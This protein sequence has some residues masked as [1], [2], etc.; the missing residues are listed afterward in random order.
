MKKYILLF[1]SAACLAVMPACSDFLDV[2]LQSSISTSNFFRTQQDFEMALNGAYHIMTSSEWDPGHRW[3][4]YFSGFLFLGRVGTDECFTAYGDNEAQLSNYTFTPSNYIVSRTWF[5]QYVG[6]SRANIVIDRMASSNVEM[7]ESE[8]DRILG[9]AYFLRGFYYFTLARYFGEVPLVL[10]EVVDVAELDTE[11]ASL[12]AVYSQVV[13]D[14]KQAEQLLPV[15]NVNG[16]A[17]R[18]AATAFLAK[19]YLQMS[20]QPLN[21]PSAAKLAAE[22]AHA[23]IE[24]G[25]FGLVEA[26]FSLFDGTN[27]YSAEYIFDAEFSNTEDATHYGGQVGTT[28]GVPNPYDLYWVQVVTCKEFYEKFDANDLRRNAI[29]DYRYIDVN[30]EPVIDRTPEAV[31]EN[32]YVYKFR[33]PLKKADRG[34][35]WVNWSN[36]LNFPVLRYAD[37]LLTYAEAVNRSQ[38]GPTPEALEYVNQVRRRGFGVDIYTPDPA[39]DLPMTGADEFN[40]M[41]LRERSFELCFEGH[42]WFDLVRF[43]QL[44]NAVKSLDKYEKTKELT[45]QARNIKPKHVILPVP[46]DVIDSSGGKIAQNPL[47][48]N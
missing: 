33:H 5:D 26:Y 38:N 24:S 41:I 11:K 37:I 22:S 3:G 30:G 15:K 48:G 10:H 19:A 9:E 29:A 40:E 20:G 44:E 32:Y 7:P 16:R 12:A 31:G 2:P 34:D 14:F 25:R 43:G 28:D 17:H 4:N 42:R 21:D 18:Y 13:S 45:Q 35:T 27:E 23:V 8:K 46:Q 47:W 36:P 39:V 1:Y 6:I